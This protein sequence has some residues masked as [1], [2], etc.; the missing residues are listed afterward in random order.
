MGNTIKI[1]KHPTKNNPNYFLI[2]S[3]FFVNRYLSKHLSYLNL[4]SG[5]SGE[6]SIEKSALW[7]NEIN[8]QLKNEIAYLFIPNVCISE[9]FKVLA[10]R[11]YDKD[12]KIIKKYK[13]YKE[14]IDEISEDL[15][16]NPKLPETQKKKQR[17]HDLET[18]RDIVIGTDRFLR[19][20]M[21]NGYKTISTFDLMLLVHGKLLLK[22]YNFNKRN[23]FIITGD[24]TLYNA[25]KPFPD[26]PRVCC[27]NINSFDSSFD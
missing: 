22:H 24:K 20:I 25:S 7:W 2:D 14:L 8:S 16:V 12:E 10:K 19:L 23:L 9:T 4:N 26:I 1:K 27:P 3:D 18:N 17:I 6:E 21:K 5:N 15:H 11:Q 13:Y